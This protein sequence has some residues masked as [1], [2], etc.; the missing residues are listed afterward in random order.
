M[1]ALVCVCV[2]V[3]ERERERESHQLNLASF[4]V[5]STCKIEH[6][7]LGNK[8]Y[9]ISAGLWIRVHYGLCVSPLVLPQSPNVKEHPPSASTS[10]SFNSHETQSMSHI[11]GKPMLAAF[12]GKGQW[13]VL[14]FCS[15]NCTHS[16]TLLQVSKWWIQAHSTSIKYASV[17]PDI[18]TASSL[19][20]MICYIWICSQYTL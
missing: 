11:S 13:S 5:F 6:I 18:V 3:R 10:S 15:R 1:C 17:P 8:G 14:P 7:G 4:L 2:C 20:T 16:G 19:P 12:M 9:N